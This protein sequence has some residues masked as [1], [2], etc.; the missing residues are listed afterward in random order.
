[1]V[2]QTPGSKSVPSPQPTGEEGYE[3]IYSVMLPMWKMQLTPTGSI[4]RREKGPKRRNDDKWE[5]TNHRWFLD[6]KK[7]GEGGRH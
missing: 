7:E 1:M 3:T 2:P 4:D 5:S 6:G